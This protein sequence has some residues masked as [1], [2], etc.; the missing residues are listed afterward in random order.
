MKIDI[1]IIYNDSCPSFEPA[2]ER[3]NEVLDELGMSSNIKSELISNDFEAKKYKFIG[4]PTIFINGVQ[5]EEVSTDIY[6]FDNCRTFKK[7]GGGLSP[8]P[9]K[10]KLIQI[11]TNQVRNNV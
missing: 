5:F 6:R 8:L 4:S 2:L 11:L 3:I 9:S 10:K 1:L 7:D